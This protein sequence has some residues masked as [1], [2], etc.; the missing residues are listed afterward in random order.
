MGRGWGPGCSTSTARRASTPLPR[1]PTHLHPRPVSRGGGAGVFEDGGGVQVTSHGFVGDSLSSG[2]VAEELSRMPFDALVIKG[3]ASGPA[4]LHIEDDSV[5]VMDAASLVG[6]SAQETATKIS[7]LLGDSDAKV[8][9][10]GPAGENLV[11]FACISNGGRQAGRTGAGAVMG[12]KNLK[13]VAFKGNMANP[14]R[15]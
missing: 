2:P 14:T 15:P 7:S 12:A 6:L 1:E 9:A 11:R 5:R 3:R 13:A 8:A 4:F 10:I